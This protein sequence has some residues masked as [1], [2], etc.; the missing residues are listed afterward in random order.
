MAEFKDLTGQ[1][2]GKLTVMKFSRD[3]K[4]GK[5]FRKYWECICECG[6]T[7]EIRTDSLTSGKVTSCG[8]LKNEQ[9]QINLIKN[10]RHKMSGTRLYGIWQKMKDRCYNSNLRSY[11]DYGARGIKIC[12]EW[13]VPDNFIDWALANGYK[14]YLTIDRID[15]NGNYEPT[16]C[17][18]STSKV[19]ARNRRSNIEVEYLGKKMTMIEVAE[20]SSISYRALIARYRR[21]IRGEKLF[22][23]LQDVG[24]SRELNYNGKIITLREL[25]EITGINLN[26]LKSRWRAGKRESEL[27][28]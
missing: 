6:K 24:E 10:H 17:R 21:G 3:V 7:N 5:R 22:L 23:P 9:D 18:W 12:D 27:Y 14:N 20:K 4:S 28:K 26:T 8:C 1:T 25:S 2:F 15:N 13:L 19:Q 11:E 16:N